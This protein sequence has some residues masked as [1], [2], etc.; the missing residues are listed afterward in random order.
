MGRRKQ[1]KGKNRQRWIDLAGAL[2]SL[3]AKK[4][5]PNAIRIL[6]E[7]IGLGEIVELLSRQSAGDE[8]VDNDAIK[9]ISRAIGRTQVRS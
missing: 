9:K 2:W 6:A 7:M 4:R 8:L 5:N 3:A 1:E